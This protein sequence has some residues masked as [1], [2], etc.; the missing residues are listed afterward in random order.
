MLHERLLRFPPDRSLGRLV[1]ADPGNHA[2]PWDPAYVSPVPAQG[3]V[4]VPAGKEARLYLRF[5]DTR[6]VDLSPLRELGPDDL[7]R[8]ALDSCNAT[9]D[10]LRHIAHLSGLPWLAIR[11]TRMTDDGLIHIGKLVTLETLYL[12]YVRVSDAGLAHLRPL[13]KLRYLELAS[14]LITANG[15]RGLNAALPSCQVVCC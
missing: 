7:D 14:S 2:P 9:D 5:A 13:T 10:D 3:D 8:L 15:V 4:V 11:D 6:H 1:I 12:E